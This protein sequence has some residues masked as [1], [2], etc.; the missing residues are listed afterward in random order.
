M[1]GLR[2]AL[3]SVCLFSCLANGQE[4]FRVEL[5]KDGQT[6]ADMRPVFLKF[7]SRPL[8]AIS[9]AE[10]ARRY[11]RLFDTTDEPA[12]RVDAL[13][14][15]TNIRDRSG[16]DIGFAPTEEAEVYRQ[17]IESYESILERGSYSGRLDELMYQ[18][19]KAYALTGQNQA[20]GKRLQMLIGLYP[21]SPLVPEARFRVAE[22]AFSAGNYVEAEAGYT[23]LVESDKEIGE[24]RNKARY[25]LGWALYKQGSQ[26]WERA[27]RRFVEVL[28]E[29]LPNA[30]SLH[31]VSE[32]NI[33]S[34]DDTLRILALMAGRRKGA[35]TLMGW[36][37]PDPLRAWTPLAFDR[38]ADLYAVQGDTEA[39]VASNRAFVQNFPAHPQRAGFMAQI[40]D[41]WNQADRPEQAR[42]AMAH[43]IVLFDEQSSYAALEPDYRAKWRTYSRFLADYHYAEGDYRTAA[44]F[45]EGLAPRSDETGELFRLAGDA[46]LQAREYPAALQNFHA[47]AYGSPG[48]GQRADAGWAAIV[49]VRAGLNGDRVSPE[50]EPDLE[51]LTS[52][53]DRFMGHYGSDSRAPGLMADLAARWLETGDNNKA[54][55][56]ATQA[57]RHEQATPETRYAAWVITAQVHQL[58]SEYGRA[59]NAWR[60]TLALTDDESATVA[61]EDKAES[62]H[63][64][65]AN[66]IY[67]QGEKAAEAG[68]TATA[69][70]HFQRIET[71]LPGSE[72]AI[73]GRFDA[74]NTLLRASQW[75]PAINELNR[76]R[77][78][79][80]SHILASD[81]S[82]KL[83]LAYTES[84]QPLRAAREL[85]AMADQAGKDAP[86]DEVWN[87]RLRAAE[88]FHTAEAR[89]QR[90]VI[91]GDYLATGPVATKADEH[92][93]LQTMRYRL[94][95]AGS[96]VAQWQADMVAA[97]LES[98]WHSEQTLQWA[99]RGSLAM[100]AEVA[101]E[102]DRIEL[103]LPLEE[104]LDRKQRA[105][106]DA[107]LHFQNA[108]SLGGE[109]VLAESLFRRAEL[110]RAMARD[111]MAS[112]A[113]EGLNELEQM[114]YRMLLE[115]EA[116]P[117]EERAI[118]LH[119]ENHQ[120]ITADGFN[121]WIER[122]LRVLAEL[123][124]GRY[125]RS[126]QWMSATMEGHEGV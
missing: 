23:E 32:S 116:Y 84:D 29:S 9:P 92:V 56:Y 124:P 82:E 107:R 71:V 14:R 50:F 55:H 109:A 62:L 21:A 30:D 42:A 85:M 11:Q 79:Y 19:A 108:V 38:L 88:L 33:D 97:E 5:G 66:V 47:A 13:N 57:I 61:M 59:E 94:I 99:A 67:W 20:S 112:A 110:H 100:G 70:A 64:H 118:D 105:M 2:V 34:I 68:D 31:Q 119:S 54:L 122:S 76:F 16:E 46:R 72:T 106:E 103:T 7:E 96:Q 39:S 58:A 52:E 93:R 28:D 63:Q 4:S 45:Y 27:G 37:Q 1:T 48:Y 60:E 41:V 3:L 126:V 115:E 113:P 104:S 49:L 80:S 121:S 51:N 8:P 25:M 81:V 123:H 44:R 74:A 90:N 111:L 98:S 65:L 73:I 77:A 43:Y 86:Y 15:L 78:D 91:Y 114:Q 35:E 6:I 125:E 53:T 12:V 17:A 89:E 22:S 117:F 120:R 10:V 101:E 75:Q 36:L 87:Y 95:E 18:M 69:V 26:A 102:F 24:L 40:V 83:I